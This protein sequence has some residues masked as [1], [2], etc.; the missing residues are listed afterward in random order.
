MIDDL[1]QS[2]LHK[3]GADLP[4]P[5]D[6]HGRRRPPRAERH[7]PSL[8]RKNQSPENQDAEMAPPN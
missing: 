3:V 7:H 1:G 4:R 6:Q 5:D 2:S 8:A